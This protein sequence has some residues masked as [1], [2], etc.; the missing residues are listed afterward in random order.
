LGLFSGLS[1]LVFAAWSLSCHGRRYQRLRAALE[2]AL[3][4]GVLQKA[5]WLAAQTEG[6]GVS[7]FDAISGLAGVGGSLLVQREHPACAHALRS[8]LQAL[9]SLTGESKGRPR[10]HTPAA[11]TMDEQLLKQ[12]PQGHFNCGLAH[13][14][15]GPL[16]L[17]ALA[18]LSGQT[19][20]GQ[21]EVIGGLADWLDRHRSDDAWGVNWPSAVPVSDGDAAANGPPSRAAWCYGAPGVARAL[22]LAGEA[23]DRQDLRE[24]ATE[25]M[26][27]VYRRPVAERRIDSPTF[28][29]GVA[30]LLQITVRFAHET[31]LPLFA[32]AAAALCQQLAAAYDPASL[33]GFRCA[34][35]GPNFVDQAGLLDGAPGVALA[36]WAASTS[37]EPTWDRL[38]L[39]S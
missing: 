5:Q 13:G 11:L 28:C 8:I 32:D 15:P 17:L 4:P 3:L 9:V 26:A 33:L 39:L 14:I 10:W 23:L 2:D 1:G 6:V 37:I 31:G 29:H 34:E 35:P 18:H 24:K 30:G 19:E 27:A 20:T 21:P 25:A 38:F 12:Y 36:L 16:A 22:W 7:A